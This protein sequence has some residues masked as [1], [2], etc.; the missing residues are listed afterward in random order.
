MNAQL[1]KIGRDRCVVPVKTPDGLVQ[2]FVFKGHQN[3][4]LNQKKVKAEVRVSERDSQQCAEQRTDTSEDLYQV[5]DEEVLPGLKRY[6][7]LAS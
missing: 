7:L 5:I 3:T 4:L 6:P 1:R 2:Y